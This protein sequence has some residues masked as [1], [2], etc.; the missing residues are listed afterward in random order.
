MDDQTRYRIGTN[1]DFTLGPYD[2]WQLRFLARTLWVNQLLGD[3][4]NLGGTRL[5]LR[6][7]AFYA[8]GQRDEPDQRVV[9]YGYLGGDERRWIPTA[10]RLWSELSQ[11]DIGGTA[12]LRFPL[13]AEAWGTIGGRIVAIGPRFHATGASSTR[14]GGCRVRTRADPETLFSAQG[15]GPIAR[16]LDFT[17]TNDSYVASQ[18]SYAAFLHARD[19]ARGSAVGVGRRAPRGVLPDRCSRRARSPRTTRP[20]SWR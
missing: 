11:T 9:K 1:A 19:A 7:S 20:R 12:Q 16:V 5:R 18:R 4:R 14:W 10:D 3:H 17:N 6:W 2:N 13:W 15:V 8:L